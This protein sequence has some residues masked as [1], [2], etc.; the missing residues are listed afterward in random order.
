MSEHDAERTA[1]ARRRVRRPAHTWWCAAAWAAFT[2]LTPWLPVLAAVGDLSGG[3][4]VW[5]VFLLGG[6]SG[7]LL[8]AH[9]GCRRAWLPSLLAVGAVA[10]L[11]VGTT[12]LALSADGTGSTVSEGVPAGLLFAAFAVLPLVAGL[13]LGRAPLCAR[14][15]WRRCSPR[16]RLPAFR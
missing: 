11:L 16:R 7:V 15:L 1:G 6:G 10:V 3:A 9:L 14:Q 4:L 8:G 2:A 12:C 5:S 13:L